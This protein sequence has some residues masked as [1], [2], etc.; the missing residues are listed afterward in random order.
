MSRTKLKRVKEKNVSRITT[1]YD[2]NYS[3]KNMLII[4]IS[5][6]AVF[7]IFYGITVIVVNKNNKEEEEINY[8]YEKS[9]IL[10]SQMLSKSE[11]KYIVLATKKDD[12]DNDSKNI[13]ESYYAEYQK[14]IVMYY[15]NLDDAMNANY[16]AEE[17]NIN[18]DL[19]DLTISDDTLFIIENGEIVDYYSGYSSIV[20]RLKQTNNSTSDTDTDIDSESETE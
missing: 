19:T 13:Y 6:I 15:I 4:I 16:I 17:E 5:L 10:V 20:A 11:E 7:F 3:M 1:D 8:T 12:S 18:S 9:Q 2:D 14:D